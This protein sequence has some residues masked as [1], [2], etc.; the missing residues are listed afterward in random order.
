M[1][2]TEFKS[3]LFGPLRAMGEQLDGLLAPVR[4][5]HG[6][7]PGQLRMLMLINVPSGMTVGQLGQH[8]FMAPGNTSNLCKRLE[9]LGLLARH[10]DQK[11]ERVVHVTLTAAG[12]AVL[13]EADQTIATY[14]EQALSAVSQADIECIQAGFDR[15][16]QVLHILQEAQSLQEGNSHE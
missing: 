9:S 14:Y 11:D 7:T 3:L 5:R 4:I 8:M 10:R 16:S 1:I 12:Q 2:H 6:L 15:L 13:A